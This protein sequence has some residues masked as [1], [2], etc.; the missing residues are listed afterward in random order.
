MS[1]IKN[2]EEKP[3]R[4]REKILWITTIII[5]ICLFSLLIWQQKQRLFSLGSFIPGDMPKL[6]LPLDKLD[7]L[8]SSIDE[9]R[10][11]QREAGEIPG[12]KQEDLKKWEGLTEEDY[13]NLNE[14]EKK[15]LE[16][17]IRE[18]QEGIKGEF[19]K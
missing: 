18:I 5:A 19:L 3:A 1:F 17:L 7:Y 6:E 16:A 12:I 11:L 10:R 13:K 4:S 8:R 15:E 9:I 2:L 14:D